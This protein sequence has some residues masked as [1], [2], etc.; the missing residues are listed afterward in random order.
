MAPQVKSQLTAKSIAFQ[1]LLYHSISL[2][3]A[4]VDDELSMM[5]SKIQIYQTPY[6]K[7]YLSEAML[8]H[9]S[10]L[11]LIRFVDS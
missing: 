10:D 11:L 2:P 9:E 5:M 6:Q 4:T 8:M 3:A 7:I 1:Q